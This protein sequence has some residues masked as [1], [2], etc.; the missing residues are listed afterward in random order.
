MM[1]RNYYQILGLPRDALPEELRSAYFA[2]AKKLHPDANP[3]SN[4]QDKFISVKQAYETLIDPEKRSAYDITLA[5]DRI[6]DSISLEI[7]YSR[8]V[9]PVIDENQLVYVMVDLVHTVDPAPTMLLPA[10]LCLVID[11]SNSMKGERLDMIKASIFKLLKILNP[12]D[13]ITIVAFS[14]RAEVIVPAK[15]IRDLP[16]IE[17]RIRL[18]NPGGGTEIYQGLETGVRQLQLLE[19][20]GVMQVRHLILFTDGHT[21]GDEA[22]C[23]ELTKQAKEDGI[24][25]NVL[26]IGHE[27]NDKF[28]DQL[29]GFGGG[30]VT[31]VT[32]P[33]NIAHSI[34]QKIKILSSLFARNITF[35]FSKDRG[36][37]LRYAFRLV[38]DTGPLPLKSPINF[39]N[40][41]YG[42]KTSVL[43]EFIVSGMKTASGRLN[44]A[45]GTLTGDLMF[46][47]NAIHYPLSFHRPFA[48]SPE[49]EAP[50]PALVEAMARLTLYRLQERARSEVEEGQITKG[51]KHLQHL[52][53]HLLASGQRE[54]ARAVLVEAEHIKQNHSFSK[55]GDKRIKY[56]T[57]ALLL[58]SG[59]E[60]KT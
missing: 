33:G 15:Q 13:H 17:Q 10:H 57:R 53:T 27:W 39:G 21:Y 54:L 47:N 46:H 25:F 34:E 29:A 18:L 28:L 50:P 23:I 3:A 4:A 6:A 8:S 43:F 58:P 38:P 14:D 41:Y 16:Q 49:P 59:L 2:Y 42:R 31:F 48:I 30:N 32:S 24:I 55:E 37:E 22:R 60:Q 19:R 51:T 52:A 35:D 56:G 44:L 45:K 7:Q 26:G 40:L 1:E 5:P 12:Q 9:L 11:V 36:A 20:S